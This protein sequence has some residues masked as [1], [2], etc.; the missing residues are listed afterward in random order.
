MV[1]GL[2]LQ[3]RILEKTQMLLY[4][5]NKCSMEKETIPEGGLKVSAELLHLKV[6][7]T[8]W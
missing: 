1:Q 5:V 4:T 8:A 2:N 6:N 3:L 7:A